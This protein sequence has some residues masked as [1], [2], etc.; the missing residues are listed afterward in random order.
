[1]CI[2]RILTSSL[3]PLHRPTETV[4][5]IVVAEITRAVASSIM[6][7]TKSTNKGIAIDAEVAQTMATAAA[8]CAIVSLVTNSMSSLSSSLTNNNNG[9][10]TATSPKKN[11]RAEDGWKEVTRRYERY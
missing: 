11:R 8:Q 2:F 4:S 3:F 5:T 10:I 1:M 9:F 6:S 7:S